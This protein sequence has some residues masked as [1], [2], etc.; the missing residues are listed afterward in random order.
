MTKC[1]CVCVVPGGESEVLVNITL[2]MKQEQL[3][4]CLHSSKSISL[5]VINVGLYLGSP[6]IGL[7]M[8]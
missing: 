1:C 6:H 7:Y 5:F 4:D 2:Q 3:T 8:T